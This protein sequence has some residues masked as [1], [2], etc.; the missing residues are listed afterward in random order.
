MST[1]GTAIPVSL[2]GESHGQGIGITVHNVPAGFALDMEALEKALDRRRSKHAY[3]T[4]RREKD[5][6]DILSGIKDGRTTG[7]PLTFFIPNSDVKSAPYESGRIRPGHADYSS[8]VKTGGA[9]DQRGGGHS[10]GRLTAPIVILGEISR[11]FLSRKNVRSVSHIHQIHDQ[12]GRSYYD[13]PM[14]EET[15]K[16]LLSSDFPVLEPSDEDRFKETILNAKDDKDS[17]G[18][19]IETVLY[20]DA[21]GYGEPFFDSFPS[22]LAHLLHSIPAVKG[23][24][25]GRGFDFAGMHGSESNDPLTV[26]DGEVVFEKNDMGGTLGGITTGQPVVFKTVIKPTS[27]IGKPQKTVNMDTK[28]AITIESGKRHDPSI[29]PRA[30]P[31]IDAMTYYALLEMVTRME[32]S[33]WTH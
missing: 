9:Y 33:H 16:R 3:S 19:I 26:K 6:F 18:G 10:S 2:F 7:S 17:V 30:L 12:K 5:M 31:V 22:V 21:A 32:G 13:Y 25:F 8:Y 24:S 28:E 23:V 14:D 1:F 27:S 29:V 15:L 4:A 11:Q 20:H